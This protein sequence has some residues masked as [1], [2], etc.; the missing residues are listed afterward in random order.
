MINVDEGE[1]T[2]RLRR[3][4]L[5]EGKTRRNMKEKKGKRNSK[6]TEIERDGDLHHRYRFAQGK[7]NL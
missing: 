2:R 3:R 6:S 7:K 5:L 1:K 4:K